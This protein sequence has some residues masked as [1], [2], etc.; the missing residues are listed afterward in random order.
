M[1]K[2]SMIFA[3]L[4]LVMSS[5][6][7]AFAGDWY[8]YSEDP[9]TFT[10]GPCTFSNVNYYNYFNSINYDGEAIEGTVI[11]LNNDGGTITYNEDNSWFE[12]IVDDGFWGTPGRI[13]TIDEGFYDT[14]TGLGT[15]YNRYIDLDFLNMDVLVEN[16]NNGLISA[17]TTIQY[18]CYSTEYNL[19]NSTKLTVNVDGVYYYYS[20]TTEE[21]RGK[22]SGVDVARPSSLTASGA[23]HENDVQWETFSWFGSNES[24]I[25]ME[26]EYYAGETGTATKSTSTVLLNGSEVDLEGYVIDGTTYYKVRDVAYALTDTEKCFDITWDSGFQVLN[27]TTH[28]PYTVVGDMLQNEGATTATYT[29][30]VDTIYKEW[31]IFNP[32]AYTIND[33]LHISI[34]DLSWM[35]NFSV[36]WDSV[37]QCINI[38]T[39]KDYNLD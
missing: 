34:R 32:Q 12:I 27:M 26:K 35:F 18:P 4:V 36:E 8:P 39:T 23:L 20:V 30:Y 29:R 33:T 11:Y 6:T 13:V 17:G 22:G 38:D 15:S 19:S 21:Y 3:T 7:I 10:L 28:K 5:V 14:S 9:Q 24:L 1:K 31:S 2:L 16:R 37:N 25:A